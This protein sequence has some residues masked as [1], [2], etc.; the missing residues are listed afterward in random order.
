MGALVK[1][2]E[3]RRR[4]KQDERLAKE[5]R[6]KVLLR[7]GFSKI[8]AMKKA[9]DEI[10][11]DK[12]LQK[13][14]DQD[15]HEEFFQVQIRKERKTIRDGRVAVGTGVHALAASAPTLEVDD[16]LADQGDDKAWA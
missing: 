12:I 4:K 9:K 13:L 5:M 10:K 8:V 7:L 11:N 15:D 6:T 2:S 16:A 14:Y 3:K 1:Y